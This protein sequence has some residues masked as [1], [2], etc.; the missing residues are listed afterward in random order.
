MDRDANLRG[1]LSNFNES[2]RSENIMESKE[3]DSNRALNHMERIGVQRS[4][5]QVPASYSN[6]ISKINSEGEVDVIEEGVTFSGRKIAQVLTLGAGGDNQS[7]VTRPRTAKVGTANVSNTLKRVNS[8]LETITEQQPAE[9]GLIAQSHGFNAQ[10]FDIEASHSFSLRNYGKDKMS[11]Q[12]IESLKEGADGGKESQLS[13][14]SK[15]HADSV[16]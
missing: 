15:I 8:Q 9:E 10:G 1:D 4:L 16:N 13:N 7:H 3:M 2:H 6:D 14:Y 5:S 11:A 12:L